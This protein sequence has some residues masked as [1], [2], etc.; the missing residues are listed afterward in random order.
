MIES[1]VFG[2][3]YVLGELEIVAG[4]AGAEPR[5]VDYNLI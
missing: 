3:H 1:D 2:V 4:V 5:L